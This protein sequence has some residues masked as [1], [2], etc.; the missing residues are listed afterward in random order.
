MKTRII[1]VRHGMTDANAKT[2]MIGRTDVSLSLMGM[3]QATALGKRLAREQSIDV[4]YAS[5]MVRTLQTASKILHFKPVPAFKATGLIE[6]DF[7]SW[8]GKSHRFIAKNFPDEYICWQETPHLHKMPSG[9]SLVEMQK[10]VFKTVT[11]IA[12]RHPGKTICIVTHGACIRS[13]MCEF[14]RYPVS[15]I[16]KIP[17]SDNTAISIVDFNPLEKNPYKIIT[18]NDHQHLVG[19]LK[20]PTFH[21][22]D[23][24]LELAKR[25]KARRD[26]IIPKPKRLAPAFTL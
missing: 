11:N 1:L 26:A 15:K 14:S 12:K 10:R 7:G 21:D 16:N 18:H 23:E 13:L 8:E 25:E 5:P 3:Q 22:L 2:L 24:I 20:P 4:V 19:N 9:E 6:I 17:W